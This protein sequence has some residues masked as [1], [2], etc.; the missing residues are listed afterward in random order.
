[1]LQTTE[2]T[3]SG[4]HAPQL[5]REN[6]HATLQRSPRVTTKSLPQRKRSRTPQQSPYVPQLRPDAA[7]NLKKKKNSRL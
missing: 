1:M 2:P 5:E 4:A 6:M 3:R 7:K